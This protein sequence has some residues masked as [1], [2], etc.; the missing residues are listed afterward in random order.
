MSMKNYD[1]ENNEH[2]NLNEIQSEFNF[3]GCWAI[4]A[5]L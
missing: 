4:F 1:D 3:R 2:L 5:F